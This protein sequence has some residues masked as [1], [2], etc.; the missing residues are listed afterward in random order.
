MITVTLGTILYP[1]DRSLS[2]LKALLEKGVINE[3][4]FIQ[5]GTSDISNLLTHP[6]VT[7]KTVVPQDELQDVINRSRLVISHAGQGSTRLLAAAQVNFILLPRLAAHGEHVDDH[8]LMFARSIEA[9]GVH[10]CT[11]LAALEQSILNPP[12]LCP[13][14]L[15]EGPKLSAHLLQRFPVTQQQPNLRLPLQPAIS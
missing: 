15:F 3:S 2:W 10:H 7:A 13:S 6:L 4:V 8:Q 12:A 5:Y 9:K 14:N 11:T 1:F